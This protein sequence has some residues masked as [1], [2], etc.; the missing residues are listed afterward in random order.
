MQDIINPTL[1][2]RD[3]FKLK[4]TNKKLFDDVFQ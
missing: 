1:S 4:L 2:V 3:L